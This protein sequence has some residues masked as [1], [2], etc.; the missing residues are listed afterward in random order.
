MMA[1]LLKASGSLAVFGVGLVLYCCMRTASRENHWMQ[2]HPLDE[3]EED[4]HG[5][6]AGSG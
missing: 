1:V 4:G 2:E 6:E 3:K 5:T